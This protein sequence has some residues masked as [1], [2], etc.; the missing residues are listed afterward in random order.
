MALTL[1]N[2]GLP[3]K[4]PCLL[5]DRSKR[6]SCGVVYDRVRRKY[7]LIARLPHALSPFAIAS[8]EIRRIEPA[9]FLKYARENYQVRSRSEMKLTDILLLAEINT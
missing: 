5:A 7:L 3:G 6:R 4:S 2:E 9:H 8:T 1:P